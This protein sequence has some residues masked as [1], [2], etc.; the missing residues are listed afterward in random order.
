M[1]IHIMVTTIITRPLRLTQDQK[2]LEDWS[3]VNI[4]GI[5]H[6]SSQWSTVK[7]KEILWRHHKLRSAVD[8]VY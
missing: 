2:N 4:F 3:I 7:G 6:R 8:M 5:Q 1:S